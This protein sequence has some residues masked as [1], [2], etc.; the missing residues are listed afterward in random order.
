M[1]LISQVNTTIA[2]LTQ[3]YQSTSWNLITNKI[4]EDQH[5]RKALSTLMENHSKGIKFSPG[6]GEIFSVFDTSKISTT[7]VVVVYP[8]ATESIP[9]YEGRDH[10]TIV[11]TPLTISEGV[12]NASL[13][14]PFVK[15]LLDEIAYRTLNTIFVFVG[16]HTEK[17]NTVVRKGQYKFFVPK[18]PD[19]DVAKIHNNINDLL[20]KIDK[21]PID[22]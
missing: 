1:S 4:L 20:K 19:F 14:A 15:Q 7:K 18:N 10:V 6:F 3:K 11:R 5:F 13:W 21:T 12:D 2:K 16:E 8:H 9:D 22:W 17:Y